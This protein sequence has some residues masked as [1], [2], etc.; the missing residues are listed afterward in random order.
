M[1]EINSQLLSLQVPYNG[2]DL[3]YTQLCAHAWIGSPCIIQS[4]L[5]YWNTWNESDA[6]LI[7]AVN[8]PSAQSPVKE[9]LVP[10][11]LLGGIQQDPVTGKVTAAQGLMATYLMWGS[12][13]YQERVYAFEAGAIS[14][15]Q[16]IQQNTTDLNIAYYADVKLKKISFILY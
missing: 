5:Y 15:L 9:L 16:S 11:Q 1:D 6:S 4:P 3:N 8:S 10:N 13:D 2:G 12:S 7:A 14:L